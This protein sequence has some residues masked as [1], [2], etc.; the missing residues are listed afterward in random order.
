MQNVFGSF[1]DVNWLMIICLLTTWS[2][3]CVGLVKGIGAVRKVKI[4]V[5][6]VMPCVV[7]CSD[8]S[9]IPPRTSP[10]GSPPSL[11]TPRET[12]SKCYVG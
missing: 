6:F 8:V 7:R 11:C 9:H 5:V 2:C 4:L 1:V 10:I 3:I 12:V